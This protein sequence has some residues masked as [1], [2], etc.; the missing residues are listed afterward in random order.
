M[1]KIFKI[2]LLV[3]FI[4]SALFFCAAGV[5]LLTPTNMELNQELLIKS[6]DFTCFYDAHNNLLDNISDSLDISEDIPEVLKNVIISA[7]DKN[8][9]KHAGIDYLR[10]VKSAAV[11]IKNGSFTQGASTISQQLVKNTHL[12]QEKTIS[13]KLKEIKLAQKLEK[14][15]SKNEILNMYLNTVYFGQNVYGI[16]NAAKYYFS[17]ELCD[18][19]LC[20]CAT[21]AGIIPSPA[22]Y[23]PVTDKSI[24]KIKRDEVLKR[25]LNNGYISESEYNN[26]VLTELK[27]DITKEN[28]DSFSYLDAVCQEIYE[29]TNI[30]P[31]D[32]TKL[33]VYTFY[34]PSVQTVLKD[35]KTEDDKDY[36]SILLDN[37]T[38]GV[39][40]YYSTC[41]TIKRS[42]ASTIKPLI[43]YAPALNEGFVYEMTKICDQPTTINGW[44]PANYKDKYYGDV[45][46]KFALSN[47]LNTPAASLYNALGKEK[48]KD[49][50]NKMEIDDSN[51]NPDISLGRMNEGITLK[52]LA[53]AYSTFS[54]LG[55]Y[56][57]TKF[58]RKITDGKGKT[59]YE[60]EKEE[61]RVFSEGTATLIND[62]LSDCVKC[63]TAKKLNGKG[64][65]LFAKTGTNGN[66]NGN[67]DA[68]VSL[69]TSMHT[70]CCWYGYADSSLMDNS[71]TGGSTPCVSADYILDNIYTDK[72][73]ENISKKGVIKLYVDK[74]SYDQNGEFLISN[75]ST[76]DKDKYEFSF[77][78]RYYP[79]K[80]KN[81]EP[82]FP[83]DITIKYDGDIIRFLSDKDFLVEIEKQNGS[84]IIKAFD[85]YLKDFSDFADKGVYYI[86]PYIKNGKE[87]TF[88]E[89]VIKN[90]DVNRKE[91]NTA[92]YEWWKE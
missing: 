52:Q 35:S 23:N 32:L 29:K 4:L 17:K 91:K 6:S 64:Y 11:N 90:V 21:L 14:T 19:D 44:T 9:Y 88:G 66:E 45:S 31:Y 30:D 73:P 39:L 92:P 43:V 12:S 69:Y 55:I 2:F 82:K 15:Y 59:V 47:S 18:L 1:K 80:I 83:D 67:T 10:I 62:M 86:K 5:F 53:Q 65:E 48:C 3:T 54:N 22:K 24:A 72:K 13:R 56:R 49:Y 61:T 81:A 74:R 27:T 8:F 78:E 60:P 7:E 58:V 68:Y 89:T 76:P 84:E 77:D 40:G 75:E 79:T 20:E 41:G 34:D 85:G 51:D 46:L 33:H 87:K 36:Q 71:I 57:S 28:S 70:I 42:P 26:A 25:T 50:L 38:G 16:K 63:G 37:I